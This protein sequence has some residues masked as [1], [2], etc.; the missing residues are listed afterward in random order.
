ML[1]KVHVPPIRGHDQ[2]EAGREGFG[3][4][5]QASGA[6]VQHACALVPQ[7]AFCFSELHAARLR[8]DGLRG[9]V[10]VLRWRHHGRSYAIAGTTSF[11]YLWNIQN[12]L[13]YQLDGI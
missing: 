5:H 6:L 4:S 1:A 12:D 9:D 7:R 10:N 3:S 13:A 2:S 11:N 8:A